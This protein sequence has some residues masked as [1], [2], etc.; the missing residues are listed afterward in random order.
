MPNFSDLVEFKV[1][2][3]EL[4]IFRR[5]LFSKDIELH[6]RREWGSHEP[7][8]REAI[9]SHLASEARTSD[10][11]SISHTEG[12][13][14]YALLRASDSWQIGLDLEL[15]HRVSPAVARRVS[16]SPEEF[17]SSPSSESLWTAKEASYKALKGMNQPAVV[18]ELN[19]GSWE[20]YDSQIETYRLE[21]LQ[22]FDFTVGYGLVFKKIPFCLSLFVCRP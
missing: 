20:T 15:V 12:V 7:G 14:G 10:T 13:G 19:I 21:N 9:R 2:Q 22:A 17:E 8:H 3:N 6:L 18:S 1:A 16:S 4:E 11:Y 5:I